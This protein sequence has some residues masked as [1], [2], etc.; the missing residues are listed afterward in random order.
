MV[1][2][3]RPPEDTG[4]EVGNK[5]RRLGVSTT[6]DLFEGMASPDSFSWTLDL[7]REEDEEDSVIS[8]QGVERKTCDAK[9]L[10][11]G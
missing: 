4:E 10:D 9:E 7:A 6:E 3:A 2:G 5:R 1:K 8:D 11:P